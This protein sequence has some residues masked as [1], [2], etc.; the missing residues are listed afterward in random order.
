MQKE[1][2]SLRPLDYDTLSEAFD[3]INNFGLYWEQCGKLEQ[4]LPAQQQLL[5]KIVDRVFVYDSHVVAIALHAD[6]GVVLDTGA[7]TPVEVVDSMHE[8]M[9]KKGADLKVCTQY[10]ADGV[11]TRDLCLDRAAC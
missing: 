8:V 7:A 6:F 9:N 5:A 3:L 1:M 11:R 10:G 2:E 4:P